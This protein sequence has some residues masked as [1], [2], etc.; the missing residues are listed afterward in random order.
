[1]SR[2]AVKSGKPAV[3]VLLGPTA[4]GKSRL[5]LQL[6]SRHPIEIISLDSAQVYRGMDIGTAKPSAA[7]RRAVPMSMP[8]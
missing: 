3:F 5:A 2:V 1:M 4:S 6:A 8:R 7:E